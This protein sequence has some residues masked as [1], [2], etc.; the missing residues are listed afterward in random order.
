MRSIVMRAAMAGVL[1]VAMAPS[2]INATQPESSNGDVGQGARISV[3]PAMNI[4]GRIISDKSGNDAGRIDSLVIDD[5]SG[6]IEY[7]L[8]EGSPN[9]DLR[10]Q[11]VAVPW[12]LIDLGPGA[13]IIS[14]GVTG[15]ELRHA[16][17]IDRSLV[18]QLVAPNWQTR[19]YGYWGYPRGVDPYGYGYLDPG[20]PNQPGFPQPEVSTAGAAG[21]NRG[22]AG[23]S[24][25]DRQSALSEANH[26]QD[27]VQGPK[28]PQRGAATGKDPEAQR[29]PSGSP[30]QSSVQ[31]PSASGDQ[32]GTDQQPRNR[33]DD[34]AASLTVNQDAVV[35]ALRS[36]STVSAS[37]LKSAE[38]Y[39]KNGS[40]IGY[41]DQVV[42][43]AAHGDIAYLLVRRDRFLG[44][45]PKWIAMPVEALTWA[46]HESGNE[47]L[48][49]DERL[50]RN[51]PAVPADKQNLVRYVR[52]RD[53]A[54]LYAHF[55]I[56]PYWQIGDSTRD[57]H[58]QMAPDAAA[59]QNPNGSEGGTHRIGGH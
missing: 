21:P 15:D 6:K 42:I 52:K 50:L 10:G 31:S 16:P 24:P 35:S 37:G 55:D 11:L 40:P 45:D 17:L 33:G 4:V 29:E 47:R 46:R 32:M 57:P 58:K 18:Y 5:R 43:D 27:Q 8:I 19:I 22:P 44:S 14:I 23:P 1:S 36:P 2:I 53:L 9:F 30:R 26:P 49:V 38:I 59:R 25:N 48:T 3:V 13:R 28:P 54:D 20:D 7:V 12:S 51:V 34:A 41:I 39:T 56:A